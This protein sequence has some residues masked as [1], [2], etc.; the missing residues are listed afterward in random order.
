MPAR[1]LRRT[2]DLWAALEEGSGEPVNKLMTSCTK[3]KG[4]PIVSI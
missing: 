1:M 2:G 4:Y 3:Q